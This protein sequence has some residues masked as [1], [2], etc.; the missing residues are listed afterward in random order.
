MWPIYIGAA[1]VTI[2]IGLIGIFMITC[3]KLMIDIVR[4]YTKEKN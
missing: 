4:S 2:M 3:I 1:L